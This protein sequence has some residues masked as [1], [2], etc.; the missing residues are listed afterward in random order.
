MKEIIQSDWKGGDAF[1]IGGGSSLRSFNFNFLDGR[2]T[3]GANEAFRLGPALCS[4]LLFADWKWWRARKF[5]LEDYARKGGI[6]YS[7]CPDTERFH[8]PW[9]RQLGR[10]S[11]LLSSQKDTLGWNHNTGAAAIN[12]AFLLGAKRIFLLGF[13]MTADPTGQTH[14]HNWRGGPTPPSSYVRFISSMAGMAAGLKGKGIEV[15]NVSDGTSK[16]PYF[17]MIG[18]KDFLRMNE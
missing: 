15:L 10:G 11:P 2:N 12:L 16:L 8:L 13:D 7:I 14:W 3:I 4:R 6:V 9:L 18:F 17:P 1:V 5:D